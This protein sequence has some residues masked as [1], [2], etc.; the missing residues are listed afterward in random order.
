MHV[1]R[2]MQKKHHR[3]QS[4]MQRLKMCYIGNT[5]QKF[6]VQ[7]TQHLNKVCAIVK[8]DKTSDPFAKHFV[9]HFQ[10]RQTKLTAGEARKHMEVSIIWQGKPISCNKTFEKLNCSLCTKERLKIL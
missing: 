1:W 10:N 9:T 8:K 7:I 3:L 2:G 4:E 5:Q 6:K